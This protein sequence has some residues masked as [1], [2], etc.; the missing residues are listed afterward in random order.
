MRPGPGLPLSEE[1]LMLGVAA[2]R[3]AG[4]LE[5]SA[6]GA[7]FARSSGLASIAALCT[8]KQDQGTHT[9]EKGDHDDDRRAGNC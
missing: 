7:D 5:P 8:V 4:D 3:W 6:I 1:T 9:R 2:F